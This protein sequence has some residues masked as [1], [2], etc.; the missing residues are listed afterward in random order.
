MYPY[1]KFRRH[2]KNLADMGIKCDRRCRQK[3]H[4]GIHIN[5]G[6]WTFDGGNM[7]GATLLS[8]C[9]NLEYD[10]TYKLCLFSLSI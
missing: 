6:N 7:I 3:R 2:F 9:D 5:S 10:T 4:H 8:N 1:V